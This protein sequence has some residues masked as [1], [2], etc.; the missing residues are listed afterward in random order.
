M[1]PAV[2]CTPV[3][4]LGKIGVDQCAAVVNTLNN[5]IEFSSL[6]RLAARER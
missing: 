6:F 3:K 4:L 1:Q 5:E 2:V